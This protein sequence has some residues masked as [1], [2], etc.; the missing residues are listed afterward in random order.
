[1][2]SK[3]LRGVIIE[4]A[5]IDI[6]G[7]DRLT[8]H[9]DGTWTYQQCNLDINPRTFKRSATRRVNRFVRKCAAAGITVEVVERKI[10]RSTFSIVFTVSEDEDQVE[11]EA[12]EEPSTPAEVAEE[13]EEPEEAVSQ[14]DGSVLIPE[15]VELPALYSHQHLGDEA[16]AQVRLHSPNGGQN[17]YVVEYDPRS[18]VAFG[19]IE[20]AD[21]AALDFFNI[22]VIQEYRSQLG[23]EVQRDVA[24][25]P[26]TLAEIMN[27]GE[28]SS[29]APVALLPATISQEKKESAPEQPASRPEASETSTSSS[30]QEDGGEAK[31]LVRIPVRQIAPGDND[32]ET[33]SGLDEL[34]SSIQANGLIE[35]LAPLVRPVEA[36]EDYLAQYERLHG[37]REVPEGVQLY[38]VVAGER[39][40]R[41]MMLNLKW[42][43]IP[44]RVQALTD[45]QAASIM[46]AENT[47]RKDLNALEEARAY[48][49]RIEKH[50]WS[51][52]EV[53]QKAGVNPNRVRE[54][55]KLLGLVHEVQHFVSTGAF[56]IGH[57]LMLDGLDAN[58]QRAA[59]KV[60]NSAK[61]MSYFDFQELVA[62]LREQQTNEDQD[63]LWNMDEL[64]QQV[65]QIADAP[66]AGKEA[67]TGAPTNPELPLIRVSMHDNVGAIM[68]RW[69]ADLLAAGKEAEAAAVGNLYDVLV[70]YK[71]TSVPS[72]PAL[73]N[74][75][76][77][78]VK[79]GLSQ[80]I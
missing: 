50:G 45:E 32:R 10:G 63:A 68:D 20:A 25:T 12:S 6:E 30:I 38:E 31:E 74:G 24:W 62:K 4:A 60:F 3:E 26:K 21:G 44:C 43:E 53:A 27:N 65:E 40:T 77:E 22:G 76:A 19:Y 18:E 80:V 56:P 52:S 48:Q 70:G 13:D 79:K 15:G 42:T 29:V 64:I 8:A 54:R 11:P 16:V 61:R 7:G 14:D 47:A 67:K 39:R 35:S 73:A 9:Q 69:I 34:A 71:W 46:L 55:I 37:D 78:T 66:S 36:S 58:R 28:V 72:V 5:G 23:L 75:E 57:A 41:A 49:R 33:F 59:L 17:W 2:S 51:V 1:M